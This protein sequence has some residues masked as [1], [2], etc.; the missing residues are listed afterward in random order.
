M[1]DIDNYLSDT[2]NYLDI[3]QSVLFNKKPDV[4]VPTKMSS[5]TNTQQLLRV[6]SKCFNTN[7][8]GA[9]CTNTNVHE[10]KN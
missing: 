3:F 10:I 4:T 5:G 6:C 1:Q 8:E 2:V 9:G 7:E